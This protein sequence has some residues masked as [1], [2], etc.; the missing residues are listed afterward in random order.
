MRTLSFRGVACVAVCGLLLEASSSIA[1]AQGAQT[2]QRQLERA[3]C[4][5]VS[6]PQLVQGPAVSEAISVPTSMLVALDKTRDGALREAVRVYETAATAQDTAAMVRALAD[7]AK[8]CHGL[9][10]GTASE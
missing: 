4:K 7:A 9:G 8:V 5:L 3:A 10:L 2:S 1:S 6:V